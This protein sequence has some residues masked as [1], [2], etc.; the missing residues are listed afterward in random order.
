M[1]FG[2]Q[3]LQSM[4]EQ[5]PTVL[6][7]W[8]RAPVPTQPAGARGEQEWPL[9]DWGGGTLRDIWLMSAECLSC[10]WLLRAGP[11]VQEE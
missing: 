7:R 5:V 4:V 8:Q 1:E 9:G 6:L 11:S 10:V 3:G 2:G